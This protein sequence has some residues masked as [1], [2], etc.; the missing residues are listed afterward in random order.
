MHRQTMN[1][2][3]IVLRSTAAV[4]GGS[5]AGRSHVGTGRPS[6]TAASWALWTALNWCSRFELLSS[7]YQTSSVRR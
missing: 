3:N 5:A 4:Q 1:F 6:L 2:I 7:E